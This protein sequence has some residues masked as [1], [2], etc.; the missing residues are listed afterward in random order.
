MATNNPPRASRRL[1]REPTVKGERF[2]VDKRER[3]MDRETGEM[4]QW[5]PDLLSV[6]LR[7][8][9]L[10]D[11]QRTIDEEGDH[12]QYPALLRLAGGDPVHFRGDLERCDRFYLATRRQQRFVW[13]VYDCGTFL[14]DD[15]RLVEWA[16][17]AVRVYGDKVRWYKFSAH[18]HRRIGLRGLV[19]SVRRLPQLPP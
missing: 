2:Y 3:L 10:N 19:E 4:I 14:F 18:S 15:C 9:R 7:A 13:G 16:E 17:A 11:A 12:P 6:Q 8:C 1:V 5:G